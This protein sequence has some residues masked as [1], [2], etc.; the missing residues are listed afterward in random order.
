MRRGQALKDKRVSG[1]QS[2]LEPGWRGFAHS[3]PK[4]SQRVFST[5]PPKVRE[6]LTTS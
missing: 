3:A 1:L 2:A 5:L 4:I 6:N